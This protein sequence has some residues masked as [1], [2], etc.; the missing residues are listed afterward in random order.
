MIDLVRWLLSSWP[1]VMRAVVLMAA[2]IVGI[3]VFLAL[4]ATI[5]F[6]LKVDPRRWGAVVGLGVV[7]M[8][9]GKVVVSVR[10]W[11]AGRG[12]LPATKLPPAGQE[13]ITRPEGG[14][15]ADRDD[16][17]DDDLSR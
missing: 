14:A 2:P 7:A 11:V 9:V 15:G 5:V 12:G 16:D 10:R 6:Y 1:R 3:L 13:Q 4:V 17:D 8:T